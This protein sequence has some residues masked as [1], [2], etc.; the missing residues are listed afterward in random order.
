V[1]HI[2]VATGE[3]VGTDDAKDQSRHETW[4]QPLIARRAPGKLFIAGEYAVLEPGCPAILIAVDRYAT[5]TVAESSGATTVN[6]D[7][8][9]GIRIECARTRNGL[10]AVNDDFTKRYEYLLAAATV[11]ERLVRERG[12][13]P[14]PFTLNAVSEDLTDRC[15]HKLG[16]G[17]SA[18]ITAATVAA[19]GAFYRLQL[20]LADRYRLAMLATL[21]VNPHASGG[22]VAASTWGGWITYRSPDRLSALAVRDGV[23]TALREPWPG[24]SVRNLASPRRVQLL[25]G[26]TGKP[27][28]TSLM[29][30][31]ISNRRK[32]S[33]KYRAFLA[34]SSAC[35]EG[36]AAAI[37]ADDVSAVQ[38][39][40]RWARKILDDFD[41]ANGL[42]IRTGKL[43]SLCNAADV[44]GAAAK[45]SGAGGGDCGIAV[46]DRDR[47]EQAAEATRR[48]LAKGIQPV[49]L[50][51]CP[52]QGDAP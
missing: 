36:L 10:I 47:P 11:V 48:W 51:I 28:T 17:S 20:T 6:S 30:S 35:V 45:I 16:L 4:C 9:G 19:M 46:V 52:S 41:A 21:T 12:G 29:T 38:N 25:V 50:Q 7:L 3:T 42:G 14:R 49:P 2:E 1:T 8:D 26:W 33:S 24:L 43:D 22:D 34:D 27:A 5:V 37:Q 44:A 23:T 40:I 15:G 32:K 39:Q 13:R 18:A 31:R